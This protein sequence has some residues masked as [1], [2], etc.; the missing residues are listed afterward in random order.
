MT[1]GAA[2]AATRAASPCRASAMKRLGL[3]VVDH[4]AGLL[5]VRCQLTGVEAEAA[6]LG[7]E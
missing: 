3:A 4:V 2:E 1:P 6:P 7:P 5:P